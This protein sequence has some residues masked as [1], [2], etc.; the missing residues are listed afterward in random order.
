MGG[1]VVSRSAFWLVVLVACAALV[2]ALVRPAAAGSDEPQPGGPRRAARR[3]HEVRDVAVAKDGSIY[4]L[5][6]RADEVIKLDKDGNLLWRTSLA[7]DDGTA[8]NAYRMVLATREPWNVYVLSVGAGVR[9][10]S[11]SGALT[12]VFPSY[13]GYTDR[14]VGMDGEGRLYFPNKEKNR[15]ERYREAVNVEAERSEDAAGT[16]V[17]LP[18]PGIFS[19][20]GSAYACGLVI[21]GSAQ[22]LAHFGRPHRVDVDSAGGRIWILDQSYTYNVFDGS[23]RFLYEIKAPDKKNRS[24]TSV[25]D[26]EFDSEGNVYVGCTETRRVLKYDPN[27]KLVKTIPTGVT[28]GP[29]GLG[30]DGS[31]YMGSHR[32]RAGFQEC[33][34]KVLDR[35]GWLVRTIGIPEEQR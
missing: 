5:D 2:S 11:T 6:R 25:T 27:G 34:I 12:R 10:V 33:Y 32:E 13:G 28:G 1:M 31:L 14:I 3:G 7:L 35:S 18:D 16:F 24:F 23:G 4:V 9:D 29:F 22:G 26:A 19:S 17:E 21:D 8:S 15:V 30:P 20:D